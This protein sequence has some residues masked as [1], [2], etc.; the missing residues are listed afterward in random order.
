MQPNTART[1]RSVHSPIPP[2]GNADR[3]LIPPERGDE[4]L[5]HGLAYGQSRNI[6]S[7]HWFSDVEAGQLMGTATVA[8]LHARKW[9]PC[10][11]NRRIPMAIARWSGKLWSADRASGTPV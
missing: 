7:A 10:A 8:R 9:K 11:S 1:I 4:L 5:A 6:C 3:Q 2:E